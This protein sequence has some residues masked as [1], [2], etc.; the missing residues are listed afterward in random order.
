MIGGGFYIGE[1]LVHVNL[2]ALASFSL[3]HRY[4]L[5]YSSSMQWSKVL[6]T[7]YF[8]CNGQH[9]PD[10]I[11]VLLPYTCVFLAAHFLRALE[12]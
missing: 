8:T 2:Y 10:T 11:K 3:Y 1:V 12:A 4:V 5:Q 9:R 7:P 6:N